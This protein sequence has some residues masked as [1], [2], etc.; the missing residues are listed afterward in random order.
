[1]TTQQQFQQEYTK[2]LAQV[3]QTGIDRGPEIESRVRHLVITR[4]RITPMR[5]YVL[6]TGLTKIGE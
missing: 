1:M 6:R 4:M 5:Y 2:A 3:R